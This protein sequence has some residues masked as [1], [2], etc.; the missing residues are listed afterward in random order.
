MLQC[1]FSNFLW[2]IDF[3]FISSSRGIS[4]PKWP[5]NDTNNRFLK[6][7]IHDPVKQKSRFLATCR[8]W[9]F[10]FL[11]FVFSDETSDDST[12]PNV[13]H[14][15]DLH[16][17]L[18]CLTGLL[19]IVTWLPFLY[20]PEHHY[21]WRNVSSFASPLLPLPGLHNV[22]MLE[23]LYIWQSLFPFTEV[24][25]FFSRVPCHFRFCPSSIHLPESFILPL[26]GASYH[27]P[28]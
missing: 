27:L 15:D 3:A 22:W 28:W 11:F 25:L 14:N 9:P 17:V 13:F 1:A 18:R 8:K 5:R 6:T 21:I 2:N 19:K 4:D 12:L 20:L 23:H 26:D 7:K 24:P 10:F 16:E